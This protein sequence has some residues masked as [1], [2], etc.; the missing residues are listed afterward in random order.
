M[1]EFESG[2]ALTWLALA[3][4]ALTAAAAAVAHLRN[5]MRIFHLSVSA[6]LPPSSAS[7]ASLSSAGDVALAS[8]QSRIGLVRESSSKG[9]SSGSTSSWRVGSFQE[10]GKLRPGDLLCVRS[11]SREGMNLLRM[12]SPAVACPSPVQ[13]Y[14]SFGKLDAQWESN[15]TS[16][17][18]PTSGTGS[19]FF[20]GSHSESRLERPG[21]RLRS[22]RSPPSKSSKDRLHILE[23]DETDVSELEDMT[24][25]VRESLRSR[26]LSLNFSGVWSQDK[27][28]SSTLDQHL[29]ALQVPWVARQVAR[30]SSYTTVIEHDGLWWRETATTAVVKTVTELRLDGRPQHQ[31]H[32]MDGSP[33]TCITSVVGDKVITH[34]KYLK[35]GHTQIVSR[36]L[37]DGGR[38]YVVQNDLKVAKD[39]VILKGTLYFTRR[40]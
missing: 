28:K 27:T 6:A 21:V 34:M 37:E 32:P 1:M 9:S 13:S 31:P 35:H 22:S 8:M 18:S 2:E 3:A 16:P 39:G 24:D 30:A 14:S 38:T 5:V 20:I 7:L 33:C 11:A 4:A 23:P 40:D 15:S 19:D 25:S 29:A 10:F 17:D 26:K 12:T 36:W